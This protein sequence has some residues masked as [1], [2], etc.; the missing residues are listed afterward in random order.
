MTTNNTG[1][2]SADDMVD[3][4]TQMGRNSEP[5]PGIVSHS[6][7]VTLTSPRFYAFLIAQALGALNDNAF[8]MTLVLFMLSVVIGEGREVRLTSMAAALVP[9]PFLLFSPLAGYF[10]DRF[11]KHRVL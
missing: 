1:Y 6:G 5:A 2:A 11:A 3:S 4:S 9:V 7:K 8:K 10:A